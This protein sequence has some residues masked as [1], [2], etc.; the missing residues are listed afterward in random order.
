MPKHKTFKWNTKDHDIDFLIARLNSVR[1]Q[2]NNNV[3]WS[4][5][6]ISHLEPVLRTALLAPDSVTEDLKRRTLNKALNKPTPDGKLYKNELLD[7]IK[8]EYSIE[9][10]VT[11]NTYYLITSLNYQGNPPKKWLSIDGTR[12][13]FSP[14]AR[15]FGPGARDEAEV[16][17]QLS[18]LSIQVGKVPLS[19][20]A[21]RVMST[22]KADAFDK[23]MAT[24]DEFRGIINLAHNRRVGLKLISSGPRHPR[25]IL[26]LGPIHTV[27]DKDGATDLSSFWYEPNFLP[28]NKIVDF[29]SDGKEHFAFFE[30]VR[31]KLKNNPLEEAARNSLRRYGTALDQTN[32]SL[33]FREI[34]SLLEYMTDTQQAHYDVTVRRIA[35]MYKDHKLAKEIAQ[36]LRV[37]RN[38]HV[39]SSINDPDDETLMDQARSFAEALLEFYIGNSFKF[40]TREEV[41]GFLDLPR[42]PAALALREKHLKAAKKYRR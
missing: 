2:S 17:K 25:N 6:E 23:A 39:H 11:K 3:S 37:R 8:D 18:R 20:V 1:T 27:H 7:S 10:K 9:A 14:N 35:A 26:R 22:S 28:P 16:D 32:W 24:L 13:D 33:A 4:A 5:A 12:I 41:G 40:K 42:D 15:F 30:K 31:N 38:K 34:W 21:V 29:N 36:H 19:P